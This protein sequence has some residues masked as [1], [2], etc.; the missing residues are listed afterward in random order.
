MLDVYRSFYG[1][2]G[3]P[4]RLGPDYRFSLHHTSY[5][6]AKAYLDYAIY[7]GEGFIA[8]TGGPGTGKTTLISEILATLDRSRVQVATLTSTQLESRDLLQMVASA[9]GMHPDGF[10]KADLLLEIESFLVKKLRSGQRAMLIVDE[11]QGLSRSALE[12][13]R[14]LANLQYQYQLLLQICLVGQESLLELIHSPGMEHLQQRLVAATALEPLSFDET[15]DY[16]EHRLGKVGWEGDPAIDEPALRLIYRYSGGTPRRINLIVNRLFLYGGMERKHRLNGTDAQ[17]VVEGLI[18]EHLLAVQPPIADDNIGAQQ[19]APGQK[20]K[21]RSLPRAG[22]PKKSSAAPASASAPAGGP[23]DRTARSAGGGLRWDTDNLP[24]SRPQAGTA[25]GSGQAAKSKPKSKTEGGSSRRESPDTPTRVR[26][27]QPSFAANSPEPPLQDSRRSHQRPPRDVEEKKTGSKGIALVALLLI[28]AGGS[29]YLLN[30]PQGVDMVNRVTHEQPEAPRPDTAE[31]VPSV[32]AGENAPVDAGGN[33]GEESSA[34]S[35]GDTLADNAVGE[36]GIIIREPSAD[37]GQP[38]SE[39]ADTAAAAEP[40]PAS[41][42]VAGDERQ[43]PGPDSVAADA[44]APAED[45]PSEPVDVAADVE[46]GTTSSPAED[47]QTDAGPPAAAT[48]MSAGEQRLASAGDSGSA[49][50]V[51]PAKPSA[52]AE[53]P[54]VRQAPPKVAT[55]TA[56]AAAAAATAPAAVQD[57]VASPVADS[58][59]AKREQLR[60]DAERRFS[61]NLAQVQSGVATPPVPAAAAVAASVPKTPPAPAAAAP[62]PTE[63]AASQPKTASAEAKK[64]PLTTVAEIKKLLL[65]GRW[66][67]SNK[68]ASLLP[69]ETTFC[70]SQADGIHCVSVPQN[71]KT[72]YGLALYKVE[73]DLSGF[74]SE[75]LFE[76]SYRTLVK[77]VDAKDADWQVTEYSMSCKLSSDDRVSCLDGKGITREYRRVAR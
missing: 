49:A 43:A 3:E 38:G 64:N 55:A 11:A 20:P 46:T 66:S 10:N 36:K 77:L 44:A 48:D 37:A 42:A 71:V 26:G 56:A 57:S 34:E 63:I 21:G 76:M 51:P 15:I 27:R 33:A 22:G 74:S 4:F 40:A 13:L 75:G 1:L 52:A 39:T 54:A 32:D 60:E 69:S 19:S 7:Q 35:V 31:P 18:E 17:S 41:E 2:S 25:T 53:S 72:Q 67:S 47:R 9:F 61:R 28:A 29:Y 68:P 30:N 8:I 70:N 6:N 45:T 50:V 59:A 73:T 14:S 5:A 24:G 12:E 62:R 58:I 65:E 23:D 16:I